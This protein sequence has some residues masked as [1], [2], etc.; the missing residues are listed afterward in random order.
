MDTFMLGRIASGSTSFVQVVIHS[1]SFGGSNVQSCTSRNIL[2]MSS[3]SETIEIVSKAG[4]D[5]V[6]LAQV[7]FHNQACKALS[8]SKS[9]SQ[10]SKPTILLMK[11]I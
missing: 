10:C 6:N 1:G 3:M 8:R 9:S 4:V 2:V 11:L 5:N 7:D